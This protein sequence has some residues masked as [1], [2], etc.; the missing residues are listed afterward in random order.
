MK[1]DPS[2]CSTRDDLQH[3]VWDLVSRFH[4]LTSRLLSLAGEGDHQAF[5]STRA[6]CAIARAEINQS[7]EQLLLHRAEHGC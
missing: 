3:R 7:R 1:R 2:N 5:A 4:N 6:D